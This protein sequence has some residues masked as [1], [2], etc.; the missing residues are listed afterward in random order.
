MSSITYALISLNFS[1][2]ENEDEL[3]HDV[4]NIFCSESDPK[5]ADKVY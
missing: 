5:Y 2:L 3:N 4:Y 1:Y